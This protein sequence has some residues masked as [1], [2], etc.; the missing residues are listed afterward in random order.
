MATISLQSKVYMQQKKS[1]SKEKEK[2]QVWILI[3]VDRLGPCST[4]TFRHIVYD[5][6]CFQV[7]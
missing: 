1:T 7:M 5:Y 2:T 4:D 3:N 6:L